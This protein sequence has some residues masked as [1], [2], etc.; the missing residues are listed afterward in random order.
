MLLIR[1]A[2]N[3]LEKLA[4]CNSSKSYLFCLL[5]FSLLL[6]LKLRPSVAGDKLAIRKYVH[7][8]H[9]DRMAPFI[10]LRVLEHKSAKNGCYTGT[11]I[12]TFHSELPFYNDMCVVTS[13]YAISLDNAPV[14]LGFLP[15]F[16]ALCG[17]L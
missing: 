17:L 16:S 14:P 2:V 12:T 15:I 10:F 8:P 3:V 13:D 7:F 5:Y 1:P 11:S 6:T 4:C 9:G